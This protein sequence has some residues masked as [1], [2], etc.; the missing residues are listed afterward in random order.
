MRQE[1][2]GLLLAHY[3]MRGVM[4]EAAAQ[5]GRDPD[6]LSFPHCW[7]V[8]RRQ[9]PNC[10]ML[11]QRRRALVC[12]RMLNELLDEVYGPRPG[13]RNPRVVKR[14]CDSFPVKRNQPTFTPIPD[15]SKRVHVLK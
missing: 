6:R 11:V 7:R 1:F 2:Y 10:A 4:N 9:L 13:H 8:L 5:A 3:V 15:S 14:K 12:Q